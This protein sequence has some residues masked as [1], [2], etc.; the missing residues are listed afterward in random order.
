M[1]VEAFLY[2]N[3][4]YATKKK[5]YNIVQKKQVPRKLFGQEQFDSVQN[6]DGVSVSHPGSVLGHSKDQVSMS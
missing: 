2:E 1:F 4:N 5:F 6:L 3:E